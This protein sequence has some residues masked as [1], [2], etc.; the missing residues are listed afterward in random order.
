MYFTETISPF[1]KM[2]VIGLDWGSE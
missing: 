1:V 2:I